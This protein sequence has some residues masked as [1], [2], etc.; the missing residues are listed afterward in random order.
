MINFLGFFYH[1][2]AFSKYFW[3]KNQC[4]IHI[5]G[6]DGVGFQSVFYKYISRFSM[7]SF[8][9]ISTYDDY[10]FKICCLVSSRCRSSRPR[11]GNLNTKIRTKC[12]RWPNSRLALYSTETKRKAPIRSGD[13]AKYH[14]KLW[15]TQRELFV[16]VSDV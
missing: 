6:R 9:I 7:F 1:N 13:S 14:A 3:I 15:L 12:K 2:I 4:L 10:L 16:R 8:S 11:F 5:R